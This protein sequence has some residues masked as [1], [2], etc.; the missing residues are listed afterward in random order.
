LLPLAKD[1]DLTISCD[2]QDIV[3]LD[4]P[5]RQD[6]IQYADILF[7]LAVNYD[8]PA[9]LFERFLAIRPEQIILVGLGA[10]GCAL[11][12]KAGIRFF[13]AV[14]LPDPVIDTYGAGDGLAIGFLSSYVLDNFSLADAVCR[15]QITARHTCIQR[16]SSSNLITPELLDYY[17]SDLSSCSD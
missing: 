7:F 8:D 5:Y 6:F 17:F 11:G 10:A 2:I 9:P 4:D 3:S 13:P 16:A 1:L 15:G 12:T 14:D